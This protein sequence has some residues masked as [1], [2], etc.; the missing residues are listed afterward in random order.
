MDMPVEKVLAHLTTRTTL[1]SL[2]VPPSFIM[3]LTM[4]MT[5]TGICPSAVKILRRQIKKAHLEIYS[6]TLTGEDLN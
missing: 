3:S 1:E 5:R 4:A 2:T 6:L